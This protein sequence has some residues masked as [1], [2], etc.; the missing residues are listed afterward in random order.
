MSYFMMG[1][2]WNLVW[3]KGFRYAFEILNL[4]RTMDNEYVEDST[5]IESMPDIPPRR[6]SKKAKHLSDSWMLSQRQ[7]EPQT[8]GSELEDFIMEVP[9]I[10]P[11]VKVNSYNSKQFPF[12]PTLIPKGQ[13]N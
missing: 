3:I 5:D 8:D 7:V 9:K 13:E 1:G 6:S 2:G 12:L 4:K 11:S 10:I